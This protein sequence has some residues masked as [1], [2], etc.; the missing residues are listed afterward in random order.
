MEIKIIYM[1]VPDRLEKIKI[2]M[3]VENQKKN[4]I[5]EIYNHKD[6]LILK[7]NYKDDKRHGE[8]IKYY[9]TEEKKVECKTFFL[10]DK[11]NGCKTTYYKNG[12]VQEI[13][14]Y[15]DDL[16]HGKS[17]LYDESGNQISE[18][19]WIYGKRKLHQM[20]CQNDIIHKIRDE[21]IEKTWN[22]YRVM[23]WCLS[24]HDLK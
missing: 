5:Y 11:I 2:K 8:Y 6:E 15:I 1:E 19:Y 3:E 21:L 22:P 10:N 14:L 24:T 12:Q 9:D 4:G 7:M 20:M 17:Y 13:T 23:D 16:P 18:S